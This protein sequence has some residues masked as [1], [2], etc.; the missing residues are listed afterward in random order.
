[1][2]FI[3]IACFVQSSLF[4]LLNFNKLVAFLLYIVSSQC[5]E[6]SLLATTV[7]ILF[8]ERRT[9]FLTGTEVVKATHGLKHGVAMGT[10]PINSEAVIFLLS[11]CCKEAFNFTFWSCSLEVRHDHVFKAAGLVLSRSESTRF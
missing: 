1:M 8:S 11:A 7:N 6:L 5:I 3:S 2:L 9:Q 4:A 10:Q